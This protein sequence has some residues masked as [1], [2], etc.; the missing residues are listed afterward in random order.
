MAAVLAMQKT[1]NDRNELQS[2]RQLLRDWVRWKRNWF[3]DLGAPHAVAWLDEVLPSRPMDGYDDPDGDDSRI[4][5]WT[6]KHVDDAVEKELTQAQR[7]A[8]K[9]I[10]LRE[11][12]P[13]VWRSNRI[14]IE[15]CKNLCLEAEVTLIKALRRRDV[16]L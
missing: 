16:R 4:H 1:N 12:G 13:A 14:P 5:A 3:P 7:V 8:V 6:M 11:T 10:Y 2:V 15:Q 9:M